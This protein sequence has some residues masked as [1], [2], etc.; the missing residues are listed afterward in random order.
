MKRKDN[1]LVLGS[2]IL[3]IPLIFAVSGNALQENA[4]FLKHTGNGLYIVE[5]QGLP[6]NCITG[7]VDDPAV[8]WSHYVTDAIYTTTCNTI[9]GYVFAGTWLNPP[10]EAQLFALGGGGTPEWGYS[11]TEF[12]VDAGDTTFTLAAVD[13]YGAGV[14][15]CKWTGP[16][17]TTPDW[18]AN[19]PGYAVSSYGP[20]AVSDDGSTIA[21]IAAPAGGDAHLLLF[22]VDDP[23]PLIDYVA[24]GLGFP[25]YVK[26]NADG[27]YTAFIALATLVVFDR[28]SLNV[29]DQISMGASNS[30]LDIS[31]DGNLV[32]YGW[33]SLVLMEWTGSSYQ[34]LWSYSAGGYYLSRIAIS[35]DGSTMVSC[36]Y[37]TPHNTIKVVVH[38]TGSSTPL[39]IYDYPTSSGTYQEVCHDIDITDDG[40]YFIIGSFGDDA[41]LNPEV[42]IFQ[43]DATPHIYYTVDMPGSMFSVDI[44]GD[45]SYATAAGKHIHANAM[46]RGGDIVMINTDITG[47]TNTE[48]INL[49]VKRLSL[50]IYPNPFHEY[51][52]IRYSIPDTRYLIQNP[53]LSIYDANGRMVKFLNPVSSIENQESEVSWNGTDSFNRKLPGGVYFVQ[54]ESGKQI[55]TRKIVIM[56]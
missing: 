36:W 53:T 40:A 30:A 25:R 16:G 19:F 14:N 39:W 12:F 46:G 34:N 3:L 13:D 43:R 18:T 55:V 23:N 51:T 42:H 47:I 21:A 5:Q 45:G 8:V 29:R 52:N 50:N 56:E 10:M 24:T 54:L 27:R 44:E 2:V 6:Y 7:P 31:G 26:I 9:D 32:A 1:I 15:V 11:G 38:D 20:F 37:N 33:P 4:V 28:D 48:S 35:N 22:D 17:D 41:N 49:P